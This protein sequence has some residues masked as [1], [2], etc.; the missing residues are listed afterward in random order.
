LRPA[1]GRQHH[2]RDWRVSFP[3]LWLLGNDAESGFYACRYLRRFNMPTKNNSLQDHLSRGRQLTITVTGRKSGRSISN[4]VWFVF[5]N[6][7][8]NL[9]P[10]SGSET[11]WY[12]NVL[13]NP[14]IRIDANGAKGELQ[15]IPV[16]DPRQVATIADRFREKYGA[17]DVKKYY[18]KF[19]VALV[20]DVS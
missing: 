19:D 13:K 4:P 2:I 9:L 18:S 1:G 3:I 7:K 17:V 6:G 14:K 11:Q 10:V 15:A 8:L 16:N 5:E 20:A 12:K